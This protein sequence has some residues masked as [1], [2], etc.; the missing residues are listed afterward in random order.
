[1][2]LFSSALRHCAGIREPG[3]LYL[4]PAEEG[5]LGAERA[6]IQ[7]RENH[8]AHRWNSA[9]LQAAMAALSSARRGPRGGRTLYHTA[10]T[11]CVRSCVHERS[12]W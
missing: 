11:A 3:M 4:A 9:G 5:L 1:V 12:A 8:T 7:G 10:D 6:W 2:S